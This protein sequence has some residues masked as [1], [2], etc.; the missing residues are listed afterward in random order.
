[1]EQNDQLKKLQFV[2]EYGSKGYSMATNVYSTAKD[3]LPASLKAKVDQVE[4]SVTEVS[5][6]Y[7]TKAQDKGAEL[8]KIVDDQVSKTVFSSVVGS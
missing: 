6:P 7:I 3:R 4:E 8:L 1:M 2:P 5:A